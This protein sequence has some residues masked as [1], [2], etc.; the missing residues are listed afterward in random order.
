MYASGRMRWLHSVMRM[1]R[2][3]PRLGGMSLGFEMAGFDVVLANEYDKDIAT[4]YKKNHS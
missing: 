1:G 4:A 2:V 3:I